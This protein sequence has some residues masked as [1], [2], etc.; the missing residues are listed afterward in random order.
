MLKFKKIM[1]RNDNYPVVKQV[2]KA[3][4]DKDFKTIK[5][6]ILQE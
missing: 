2:L 1:H 5:G 6:D 4:I 3:L